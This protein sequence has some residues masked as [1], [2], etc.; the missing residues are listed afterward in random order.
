M[1]YKKIN[2]ITASLPRLR[3]GTKPLEVTTNDDEETIEVYAIKGIDG[4]YIRLRMAEDSY[5]E[6]EYVAGIEFVKAVE[7]T[8]LT[9]E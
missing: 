7:K 9:Y 1:D 5:D 4:L 2:E 3:N 8:V 6:N